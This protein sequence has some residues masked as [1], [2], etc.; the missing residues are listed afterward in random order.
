MR[1]GFKFER[2][3]LKVR[4]GNRVVIELSRGGWAE[5]GEE[6]VSVLRTESVSEGMSFITAFENETGAKQ[7]DYSVG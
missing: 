1:D 3:D 4:T 6:K 5:A 2:K 7:L